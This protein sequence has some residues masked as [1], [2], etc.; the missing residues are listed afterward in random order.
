MFLQYTII[1]TNIMMNIEALNLEF[2]YVDV[3]CA[4]IKLIEPTGLFL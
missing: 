1:Y 3:R 4:S 2:T